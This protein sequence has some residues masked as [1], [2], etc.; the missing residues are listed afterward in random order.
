M[1]TAASSAATCP[2]CLDRLDNVAFLNPCLHQFCFGCVQRWSNTKA[3]CPLC[4]RPIRSILHSVVADDNFQE[5]TVGPP[6]GGSITSLQ[7][8]GAGFY[9]TLHLLQPNPSPPRLP[10]PPENGTGL[11]RPLGSAV[12]RQREAARPSPSRSPDSRRTARPAAALRGQAPEQEQGPNSHR[13]GHRA[14]WQAPAVPDSDRLPG[15]SAAF[16]QRNPALLHILLPWLKRELRSLFGVRRTLAAVVEFVIISNVRRYDMGSPAFAANLRP[17]LLGRT[18]Q[19][20]GKFIAEARRATTGEV[21]ASRGSSDPRV[22]AGMQ[23]H[24]STSSSP[25]TPPATDGLPASMQG[26]SQTRRPPVPGHEELPR[27]TVTLAQEAV[28]AARSPQQLQGGCDEAAPREGRGVQRPLRAAVP[29]ARTE[30]QDE[31]M[32]A[33][34]GISAEDGVCSPSTPG[35]SRT[36]SPGSHRISQKRRASSPQA[37][38]QPGKKQSRLQ[39]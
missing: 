14:A 12:P 29:S 19:F 5:L 27:A 34:A 8:R 22:P 20:I 39:H 38:S 24:P 13:P 9:H 33:M 2:I 21:V 17:F 3:E 35:S 28:A 37:H 36:G 32:E 10:S 6:A 31:E 11:P 7:P 25:D 26:P 1:A 30:S 4:K 16:F 18:E 23:G 15:L